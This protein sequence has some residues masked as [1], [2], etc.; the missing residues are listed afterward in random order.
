MP[1]RLS[2]KKAS[3]LAAK[4]E[5]MSSEITLVDS[6]H[7]RSDKQT[8][9]GPSTKKTKMTWK[10]ARAHCKKQENWEARVSAAI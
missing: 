4:P 5:A 9:A 2:T 10:E 1:L 6:S 3:T 7:T 8:T